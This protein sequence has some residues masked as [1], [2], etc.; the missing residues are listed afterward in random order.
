MSDPDTNGDA[1]D[2]WDA[3]ADAADI[4]DWDPE[5]PDAHWPETD[6]DPEPE[7]PTKAESTIG[8]WTGKAIATIPKPLL[9][10]RETLFKRMAL[11][12]I[13]NYYKTVS[14]SDA[15][16]INA[17]AGQRLDLEPVAYR[18]PDECEDDEKPGWYAQNRDKSWDPA[19][20]GGSVNFLGGKTPTILLEDDDHVEAGTLA[21]RIGQAI[22][23]DNYWPL[24]TDANIN[25]VLDASPGAN[26]ARADGGMGVELEL[27]SPG[28]WAGDNVIDLSSA[29][30]HDGMRI[31]TKKAKE[32]RPERADSE[33]MKRAEDRGRLMEA[34]GGEDTDV[35]RLFLYAALLVIGVLAVVL[36][37]PELVGG[38]G[39]G[40]IN[41]LTVMPSA[42]L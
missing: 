9:G 41:P 30:G 33:A 8:R 29:D 35:V 14:G 1:P 34:L 23:L 3:D 7:R 37:G 15:I 13:N 11:K 39:G 19:A 18:A 24:F 16:A 32:W 21:P 36:L 17:K 12:A 25:A 4:D 27:D 22:E 20:D 5:D 6:T 31:S 10:V 2:E 28:K 26:G 42:P 38:G 40:G